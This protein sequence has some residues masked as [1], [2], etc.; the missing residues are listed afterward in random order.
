MSNTSRRDFLKAL[1]PTVALSAAQVARGQQAG[2]GTAGPGKRPNVLFIMADQFRFDAIAALGNSSIYTPNIDRLVSRG[3]TFTNAYSQCPVCVPARYVIRTGCE[4]PTT[5]IFQNGAPYLLEGQDPSMTGRCGPYI[6]Q[7][8]KQLGYRTFGIG[9]FH[10]MP[11]DEQ[12]GYD[13]HLH[14]EELYAT[15]DQ[16]ARDSSAAWIRTERPA[17]DFVEGLM[18]ERTDMYYMPQMSPMPAEATVERWAAQRAIEQIAINGSEPYFG[19]VSFVGPHPP[20]APPIP[21][22]RLYD[23]DRMSNPVRG[24]TAVDH[25]DEQIPFMNYAIWAEDVNDPHVRVLKARY[26]GEITYIDDC[27]GRILKAVEARGDADNTL[28]CFFSDHGDHLGDHS[29]W[30]KESFFE[31]SAHVPFLISW[32]GRIPAGAKRDAL[33]A[34]TDLFGIA[35]SAAGKPEFRQGHDALGV[36]A[37]TVKP[38]DYLFGYYG[39]PGTPLF[40]IMV[41]HANWKYIFLANGGREQLFNLREDPNELRNRTGSDREVALALRDRAIQACAKPEARLAL[42]GNDLRTFPFAA[43]PL[44][45]I[46]QFDRSRGITGFPGSPAEVLKNRT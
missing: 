40:K 5:R 23:P 2:T 24:D 17:Y 36:I 15:P 20:F 46:Y 9:K 25:M 30:Q 1:G 35:T 8:M 29:A 43:R 38:R 45:R 31:A 3:V 11:W 14:S 16:R 34:L 26:Y 6:A 41:R 22:N 44:K 42:S 7:T 27:V 37:G 18:G 33:V 12:L 13:V 21:F 39:E 28:I 32:P 19:F 10:T 4:P